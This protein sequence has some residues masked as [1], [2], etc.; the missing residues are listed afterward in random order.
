MVYYAGH[1]LEIG[2]VNYLVPV[3]ARLAADKDAETEA[4]ALEQV[5][6]AV[7]ARASCGW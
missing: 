3:D 5:I 7:A 4:V 1:G 2:G 6:A